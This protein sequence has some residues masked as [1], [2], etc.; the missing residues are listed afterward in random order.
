MMDLKII[1]SKNYLQTLE[2]IKKRVK[3]AQLRAHFYSKETT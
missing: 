1:E 2:G 3:S